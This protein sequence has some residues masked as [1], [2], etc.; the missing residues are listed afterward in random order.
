MLDSYSLVY[1]ISL[2]YLLFLQVD[3]RLLVLAVESFQYHKSGPQI[4]LLS[5]DRL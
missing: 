2:N 1:L 5:G 4:V 3:V